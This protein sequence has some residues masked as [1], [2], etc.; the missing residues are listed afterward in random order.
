MTSDSPLTP[1]RGKR[2]DRKRPT[3]IGVIQR[4][5]LQADV[6]IPLTGC[7]R[8]GSPSRLNALATCGLKSPKDGADT[9][10]CLLALVASGSWCRQLE[11]LRCAE[12]MYSNFE[13]A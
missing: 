11:E 5:I 8:D 10:D 9:T 3:Q 4:T 2:A 6:L 13:K 7:R 1:M 12:T